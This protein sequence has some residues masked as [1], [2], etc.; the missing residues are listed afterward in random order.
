MQTYQGSCH[1]GAVRYRVT[2]DPPSKAFACNCS[3]CAR[4]GWLMAFVDGSKFQLEHGADALADYQFGKKRVHHQFCR[5]CGVRAF[6][7]GVADNG[8]KTIS[9]NLRCLEGFDP[10]KLAVETFDGASL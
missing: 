9:V 3:I 6:S 10:T 8:S 2:M 5:T 4:A 1:C 7:H